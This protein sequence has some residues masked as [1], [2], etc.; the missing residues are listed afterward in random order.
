MLKVKI[1]SGTYGHNTG[2]H[3]EP[4]DRT[5]EPFL[6]DKEEAKRL[7]SLGV[8]EIATGDVATGGSN[9]ETVTPSVNPTDGENGSNGEIMLNGHLDAEQLKEMTNKELK[10][11]A[12]DMGIDT[13]KMKIKNDYIEAIIA[14]E[15]SVP[16]DG[17]TPP[18]ISPEAPVI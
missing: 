15:V 2:K 7:I 6:L 1:I 18:D 13:S 12:E 4:K 9:G 10:A 17:E 11:L 16:T 5:S 3:I 14:E 8:A